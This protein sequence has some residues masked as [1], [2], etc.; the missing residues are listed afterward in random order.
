MNYMRFWAASGESEKT[1]IRVKAV[2]TQM[3]QD[4]IRR[5]GNRPYGYRLVHKGRIG[6]KNRPLYDLEIDEDQISP[7]P[8]SWVHLLCIPTASRPLTIPI[9]E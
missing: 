6:K 1:S 8:S 7:S 5:G 3:T 4:G 9:N 2:H